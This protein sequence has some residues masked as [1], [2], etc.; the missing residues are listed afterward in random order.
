[1][2]E[3]VSSNPKAKGHA[4]CGGSDDGGLLNVLGGRKYLVI[5]HLEVKLGENGRNQD[6]RCEVSNVRQRISV[7][8]SN[9]VESPV[10]HT[11]PQTSIFFFKHMERRCRMADDPCLLHGGELGLGGYQLLGIQLQGFAKIGGQVSR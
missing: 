5:P 9:S 7:R 1:M 8:N 3:C 10:I 4:D 2:L 11:G 6:P